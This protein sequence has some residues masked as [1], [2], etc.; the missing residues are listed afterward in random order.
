M[1]RFAKHVCLILSFVLLL[2]MPAQ[3]AE[4]NG[5]RAS[6]YFSN[7]AIY[8]YKTSSTTFQ[9]WFEVTCV[10]QMDKMGAKEIKIQK[11]SDNENWTTVATY[12]MDDYY[13]TLICED[14]VVHAAC[15]TYTGS[16]GYYYRAYYKLYAKDDTGSGTWARYSSSIYIS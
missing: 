9:A 6:N 13:S 8:L 2:A 3:A 14:T 11:S 1:K 7:S 15:V 10:R 16:R 12:T 5:A 4:L